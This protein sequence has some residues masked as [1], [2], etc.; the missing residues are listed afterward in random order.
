MCGRK[1]GIGILTIKYFLRM[2][3]VREDG[4]FEYLKEWRIEAYT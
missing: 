3:L 4:S 1:G 2:E